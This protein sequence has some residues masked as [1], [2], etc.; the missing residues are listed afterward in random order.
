MLST[1]GLVTQSDQRGFGSRLSAPKNCSSSLAPG[2]GSTS[3]LRESIARG[4]REWGRGRFAGTSSIGRVFRSCRWP[5]NPDWA[6]APVFHA[7]CW[8]LRS[9]WLMDSILLFDCGRALP[10]F[11]CSHRRRA[12]V[13][14]EHR[15]IAE[16]AIE[17]KTAL[18]IGCSTIIR[19]DKCDAASA[20]SRPAGSRGV[21]AARLPSD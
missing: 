10:K 15:A 4:G 16:A 11:A 9:R 18:A 21:D 13:H 2:A 3:C 14:S 20:R 8:R 5:V 6:I 19:E 12:D 1:E 17:R 7:P